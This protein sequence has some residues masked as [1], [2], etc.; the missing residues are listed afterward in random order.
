MPRNGKNLQILSGKPTIPPI[1]SV[2]CKQT[3][4]QKI[5][6]NPNASNHFV[7][8]LKNLDSRQIVTILNKDIVD[9]IYSHTF[10]NG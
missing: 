6:R 4:G 2:K 7:N 10:E 3:S 9:N 5:P 1:K 8:K